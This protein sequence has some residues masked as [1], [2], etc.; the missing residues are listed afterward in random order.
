MLCLLRLTYPRLQQ[1]YLP[2]AAA[3]R[4]RLLDK[5]AE[6][7]DELTAS[8]YYDRHRNSH[9]ATDGEDKWSQVYSYAFSESLTGCVAQL[10]ELERYTKLVVG[11]QG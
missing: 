7:E 8:G 11:E 9:L 2:S 3:A 1:R 4:K 6:V 5:M 10:E